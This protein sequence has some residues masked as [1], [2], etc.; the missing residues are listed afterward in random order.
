MQQELETKLRDFLT[1]KIDGEDQVVYIMVE[2]RKLIDRVDPKG[3]KWFGLK[4]YCNWVV[5]TSLE[6]GLAVGILKQFESHFLKLKK[7]NEREANKEFVGFEF[8]R[9]LLC[10]FCDEYNLPVEFLSLPNWD[11][12]TKL[13]SE[14]L[15]DCPLSKPSG[16][17]R[18]FYYIRKEH[19]PEAK[20]SISWV[21]ELNEGKKIEGTI[22]RS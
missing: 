3:K 5:H 14:I 1:K 13:L 15:I 12:F 8:L 10:K 9:I 17:V 20:Y 7:F 11:I 19:L 4:L 22:L 6:R 18:S 16:L 21:I 2:L